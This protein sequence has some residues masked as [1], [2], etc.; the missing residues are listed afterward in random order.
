MLSKIIYLVD[1]REKVIFYQCMRIIYEGDFKKKKENR[2][3][4]FFYSW[5]D[6]FL[7]I[8]F[9]GSNYDQFLS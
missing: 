5:L 2:N 3:C 1:Y 9:F 8:Y 6:I 4:S 7:Y